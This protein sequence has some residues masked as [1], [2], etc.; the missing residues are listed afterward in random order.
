MGQGVNTR[1]RQIVAD[2]L[3]ISYDAVIIGTTSTEKNHNTSP[4]AASSGT[5]LNGAAAVDACRRIRERLAEFLAHSVFCDAKAGWSASPA[6]IRFVD[7]WVW[8]ERTPEKRISFRDACCRAYFE[9]VNLGERGFY[10]TPGVDF[11]RETGKGHPFL[12][13]TNGVA[14]S[15]V[16]IDRFTGEMRVARVDLLMDLGKMINPG[17]DRGQVV[18]GFIQGMGWVTNEELKYDEK[19]ELLS[20]SP[21]TYKIPNIGDLPAEFNVAFL[22]NPNCTV[23][24]MGS[25]AMGEPPLL[26]GISVWAAAKNALSYLSGREA[27]KIS[28]PA[29]GEQLLMRITEYEKA[30]APSEAPVVAK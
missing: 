10:V 22:D 8:D 6:S 20:H 14:C 11:N 17:V 28:I 30:A 5:D 3:G 13:Y 15:E 27:A 4:T 7:G 12:Y 2:E 25:K 1:V 26:L 16:L 24:L 21:T 9:R 23:S 19:G 29:T 18:G